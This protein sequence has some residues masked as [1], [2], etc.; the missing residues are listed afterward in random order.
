MKE[1][2]RN[3][4]RCLAL[5]VMTA[6]VLRPV[7]VSAHNASL[8]G[9][10]VFSAHSPLSSLAGQTTDDHR[11]ATAGSFNLLRTIQKE[12][13]D[14]TPLDP[15]VSRVVVFQVEKDGLSPRFVQPSS[16]SLQTFQVLRI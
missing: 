15:S 11:L 12:K 6:L 16:S 9:S 4:G 5:V 7:V 10:F 13:Q 2:L 14:P 8:P 1:N 3:L